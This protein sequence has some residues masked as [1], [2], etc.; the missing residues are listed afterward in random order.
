MI[1]D[2]WFTK[3][4][5]AAVKKI[6]AVSTSPVYYYEFSFDGPFGIIKRLLGAEDLPGKLP[7]VAERLRVPTNK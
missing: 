7:S 5:N 4:I 1:T 2:E 6:A 3:D